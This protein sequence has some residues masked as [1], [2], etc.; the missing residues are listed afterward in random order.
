MAN[1]H[2]VTGIILAGGKSSRMGF[3]K[4]LAQFKGKKMIEHVLDVLQEVTNE[5]IIVANSDSYNFLGY[6]VYRDLVKEVGPLGGIYTGLHYSS[7]QKNIVVACDMPQ[8]STK[9]LNSLLVNDGFEIV[10]GKLGGRLEP[11]CAYYEK[12]IQLSLKDLIDSNS[13]SMQRAVKSF[14]TKVVEIDESESGSLKNIN[15]PQDLE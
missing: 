11:L 13:L 3:D 1:K 4:G 2:K 12:A 6:P 5:I 9:V 8:L 14:R 10:L 7:T 15:T